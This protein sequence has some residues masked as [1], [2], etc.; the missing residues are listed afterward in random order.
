MT[1]AR[2][3]CSYRG[4][5]L[6]QRPDGSCYA[7][8]PMEPFSFDAVHDLC[9]RREMGTFDSSVAAMDALRDYVRSTWDGR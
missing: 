7:L 6:M 9:R 1:G 2:E 3:L 5:S 8:V 4:V